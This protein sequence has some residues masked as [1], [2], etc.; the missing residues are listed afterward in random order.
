MAGDSVV[1]IH[2]GKDLERHMI[3]DILDRGAV[4][5]RR[6]VRQL[7]GAALELL[8]PLS[9]L[10]CQ[11]EG[12]VLCASCADDLPTLKPPFCH[13]CAQPNAPA[14]CHWCLESPPS[15][16]GLRAPYQMEG[17]VKDAI[18]N[19]KYRG[20][21]A[22][23][24]E[25]ADL[26]AHYVEEHPMPGDILVPVPLHPRRLRSRG[27]NQSALLA[28]ELAKRIGVDMDERLLTRAKNTPPQVSASREGRRENVQGSFR[29]NGP[30]DGQA[31]ILVDDVAT[32]GS[33]LSAC[34]AALKTAGAS[35]VWCLVLARE[36]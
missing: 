33:T 29:C 23:A 15:F 4:A 3:A 36:S 5:A 7:P 22:A 32:T 6:M 21:K 19:L 30:V 1:P 26:L 28:K 2:P 12:K 18:H 10:G 34:A 14:T 16:D 25:L 11:R 9:C 35:S 31:V 24:P 20:L 13:I 27:Y 17:I 8:F